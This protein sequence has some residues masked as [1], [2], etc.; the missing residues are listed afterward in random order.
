MVTTQA[1]GR[2][3]GGLFLDITKRMALKYLYE[4]KIAHLTED[5]LRA[6]LLLAL[7]TSF[8]GCEVRA[9]L[10]FDKVSSC[11]RRLVLSCEQHVLTFSIG[12]PTCRRQL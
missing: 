9:G 5:E 6:V 8:T 12:H 3:Q 2:V 10:V 11:A 1:H 4:T 7:R